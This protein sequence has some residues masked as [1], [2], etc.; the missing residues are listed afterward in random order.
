MLNVSE[1][2]TSMGQSFADSLTSG[3]LYWSLVYFDKMLSDDVG[4]QANI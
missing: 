2:L 1:K 4:R 3:K